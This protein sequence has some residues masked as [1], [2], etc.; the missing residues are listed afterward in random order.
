MGN[1][2]VEAQIREL[3]G[4]LEQNCKLLGLKPPLEY[5]TYRNLWCVVVEKLSLDTIQALDKM[6]GEDYMRDDVYGFLHR[7]LRERLTLIH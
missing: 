4:L 2:E 1:S 6:M 3:M 5:G 7:K